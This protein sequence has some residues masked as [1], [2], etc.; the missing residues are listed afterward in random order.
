MLRKHMNVIKSMKAF[1]RMSLGKK[2]IEKVGISTVRSGLMAI[3]LIIRK[4]TKNGVKEKRRHPES[5]CITGKIIMLIDI[6][7]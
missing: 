2:R 1:Y 6:Y 3:Y 5:R 7:Y 4:P